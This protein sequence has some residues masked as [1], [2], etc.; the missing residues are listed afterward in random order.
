MNIKELTELAS[1][2]PTGRYGSAQWWCEKDEQI[3]ARDA[4]EAHRAEHFGPLLEALEVVNNELND[5]TEHSMVQFEVMCEKLF[6]I[7][8]KAL[9]EASEVVV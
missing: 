1:K 8:S 9:K 4:L 6:L 2:G 7:T 3:D 5:S